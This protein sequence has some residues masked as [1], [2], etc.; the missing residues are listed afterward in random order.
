LGINKKIAISA[1]LVVVV[2]LVFVTSN[3]NNQAPV[4]E[5]KEL[6]HG[7]KYGIYALDLETQETELIY[8]TPYKMSKIRLNKAGDRFVFAKSFGNQTDESVSVS[9]ANPDQEICTMK[10]DGT[11]YIQITNDNNW[12]L[13]PCWISDDSKIAYLSCRETLDIFLMD[14]DGSNPVL[15]Y[16][17]GGHDSDM[18]YGN[19]KIVFTRDSQIWIIKED[20]TGLTQ[21]TDPPR[22]GEWGNAVL[23]FGDYD[24]FWSFDGTKLV[25]E[26]M[27]DD[28]TTHG[29]YEIY[30]V[31]AD[32]TQETALTNTRY[33][34]GIA[35]WS[36]SDQKIVYMVS[37]IQNQGC[38]DLYMMNADGSDQH[39]I[40]P[41][42]YPPEFLCHH[43]IF[44]LDDSK[45]YFIGE[46]YTD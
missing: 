15:V 7:Y 17:S 38:Y 45:V 20:G 2:A 30:V 19:G 27:V 41:D 11:E 8:S 14:S 44:S 3:T 32:G 10:V 4:L 34:Q 28:E 25:F 35:S 39:K 13:I 21:I 37:A 23:P 46:W 5:N 36:H 26:R 29:I 42:Y 9:S 24:P 1:V 6:K 40:I 33:T 22:A 31:N 43:P 16:D 12:D 18:H